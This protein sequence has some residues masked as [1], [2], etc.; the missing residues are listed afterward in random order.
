MINLNPEMIVMRNDEVT[1]EKLAKEYSA[2]QELKKHYERKAYLLGL[3]LTTYC[4]RCNVKVG[5]DD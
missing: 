3:S 5:L 1:I 4:A 2:K